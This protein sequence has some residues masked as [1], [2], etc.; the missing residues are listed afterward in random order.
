M[1]MRVGIIVQVKQG[2]GK[3]ARSLMNEPIRDGYY[4]HDID[5]KPALYR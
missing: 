5:M 2:Y 4:H 1:S 3:G